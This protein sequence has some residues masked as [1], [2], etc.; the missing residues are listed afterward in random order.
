VKTTWFLLLCFAITSQHA[1][2]QNNIYY[3]SSDSLTVN[4]RLAHATDTPSKQL[5]KVGLALPI[6][7][8][9]S[10]RGFYKTLALN[11]F[12]EQKIGAFSLLSGLQANVGFA[13]GSNLFQLELPFDLRYYFPIGRRMKQRQDKH[14]FYSYYVG[15]HTQN[16]IYTRLK[17]TQGPGLSYFDI[18]RY[19]RGQILSQTVNNGL[20]HESFNFLQYAHLQIGR[21]YKPLERYFLDVNIVIPV[22]AL[23][24]NKWDYTLASPAFA[25]VTF[26][27]TLDGK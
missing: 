23:V 2:G 26:G 4:K 24:Y 7:R 11:A 8:Q 21:Q 13:N 16:N 25:T 27:Y 14:S 5:I 10:F 9:S 18:D 1:L 17:Y 15:I 20:I 12:V 3:G 19:Q 22:S 6:L